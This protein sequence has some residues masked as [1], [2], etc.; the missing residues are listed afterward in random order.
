MNRIRDYITKIKTSL[1]PNYTNEDKK[2]FF[3]SNYEGNL[4]RI[5]IFGVLKIFIQ[6]IYCTYLFFTLQNNHQYMIDYFIL[7]F[8]EIIIIFL[9]IVIT[10]NYKMNRSLFNI[11]LLLYLATESIMIYIEL[12]ITGNIIRYFLLVSFILYVPLFS[13]LLAGINLTLV[14]LFLSISLWARS[15]YLLTSPFNLALYS[16]LAT[17]MM[18]STFIFVFH[19]QIY[20]FTLRQQSIIESKKIEDSNAQLLLLNYK[21]ESLATTDHLTQIPNRRAFDDYLKKVWG[22]CQREGR[23]VSIMIIDIDFFK[24]FNDNYGHL[25]GDNTLKEVA[26]CI[27]SNFKRHADL[28]AR[29]GGEEFGSVIPFS[30]KDD[31]HLFGEKIRKAVED[32]RMVEVEGNTTIQ[33]TVSIGIATRIPSRDSS[34]VELIGLADAALYKAKESGRNKVVVDSLNNN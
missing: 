30:D 23:A 27:G 31:L 10:N 3:D 25:V 5:S 19:I 29:Y 21:L 11:F 20:N 6:I 4:L 1:I 33:V 14:Y 22:Q 18:F 12:P 34:I 15:E 13:I 17:I 8:I 9:F 32:L 16:L 26:A 24:K 7:T 28:F 2:I